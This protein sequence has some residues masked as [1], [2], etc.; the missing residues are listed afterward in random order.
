MTSQT[1]E[2]IQKLLNA[3]AQAQKVVESARNNKAERLRQAQA[4][5]EQ[6][7]NAFRAE[8][9]ANYLKKSKEGA[10]GNDATF[11]SLQKDADMAVAKIS[12]EVS[13]KKSKVVDM[14]INMI[15][16]VKLGA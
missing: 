12:T 5:A 16:T 9:E 8:C 13:S 2:G 7:L 1:S 4:E 6:E 3:E 14:L 10:A 11:A 15:T